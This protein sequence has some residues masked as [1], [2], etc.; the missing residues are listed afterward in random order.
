MMITADPMQSLP[1]CPNSSPTLTTPISAKDGTTSFP[2]VLVIA[3]SERFDNK[4]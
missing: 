1:E 4:E 2:R 3:T